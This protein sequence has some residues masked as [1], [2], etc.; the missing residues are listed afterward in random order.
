MQGKGDS[1][2]TINTADSPLLL[3][4]P[5]VP[6]QKAVHPSKKEAIEARECEVRE[7]PRYLRPIEIAALEEGKGVS[8]GHYQRPK[9]ELLPVPHHY[10]AQ[11]FDLPPPPAPFSCQSCLLS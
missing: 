7:T 2:S 8:T 5:P 4:D 10:P 6:E 9:A 3:P 11:S 1:F